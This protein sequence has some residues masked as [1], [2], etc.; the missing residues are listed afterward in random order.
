MFQE[1]FNYFK[2][3]NISLVNFKV[4]DGNKSIHL[5]S[6]EQSNNKIS[7]NYVIEAREKSIK[8]T[9]E[10]FKLN[11][12]LNNRP[13]N[14]LQEIRNLKNI[15]EQ[16]KEKKKQKLIEKIQSSVLGLKKGMCLKQENYEK[17]EADGIQARLAA[18]TAVKK[19]KI[20]AEEKLKKIEYENCI[21]TTQVAKENEIIG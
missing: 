1:N 6:S 15:Q 2:H 18:A 3:T 21:K 13:K 20:V 19:Q 10:D 9:L 17:K 5:T 12:D 8:D 14:K 11:I 7:E 16:A 4:E